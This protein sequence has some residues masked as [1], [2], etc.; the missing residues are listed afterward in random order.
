[1]KRMTGGSS[2]TLELR[3]L[4]GFVVLKKFAHKRMLAVKLHKQAV[5]VAMLQETRSPKSLSCSIDHYLCYFGASLQGNYGCA[6][7]ISKHLPFQ[8]YNDNV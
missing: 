1:M 7:Y 2:H 6:V 3:E 8:L 5:H 4:G